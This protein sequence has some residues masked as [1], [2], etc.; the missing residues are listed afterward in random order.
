[1]PTYSPTLLHTD[2]DDEISLLDHKIPSSN[3][4]DKVSENSQLF[5]THNQII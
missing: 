5:D 1:M 3:P 2:D 4:F